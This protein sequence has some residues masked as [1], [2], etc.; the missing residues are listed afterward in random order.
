MPAPLLYRSAA[1]FREL[2]ARAEIARASRVRL[3]AS[4]RQHHR[5][6]ANFLFLAFGLRNN[7]A[8]LAMFA[9]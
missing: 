2:V 7:A 4:A 6:R 9:D 3:E 1:H 5:F 8:N